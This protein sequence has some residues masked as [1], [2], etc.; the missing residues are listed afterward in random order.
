M[1]G[2]LVAVLAIS[3]SVATTLVQAIFHGTSLSRCKTI[4]CCCLK[5]ERDVLQD[6]SIYLNDNNNT[7]NTNNTNTNE[8]N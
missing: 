6:E 1:S 7:N 8:I 3:G 4:A 5:C 2:E